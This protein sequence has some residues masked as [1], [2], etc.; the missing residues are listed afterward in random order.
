MS[1]VK[2]ERELELERGMDAPLRELWMSDSRSFGL[3]SFIYSDSRIVV[4]IVMPR[5]EGE[6]SEPTKVRLPFPFD[7]Q[8][9]NPLLVVWVKRRK[10]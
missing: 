3:S 10:E 1:S 6:G 7:H 8:P 5:M 9:T 2:V 4:R